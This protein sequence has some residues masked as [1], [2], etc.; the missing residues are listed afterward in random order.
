MSTLDQAKTIAE[1]ARREKSEKEA[2]AVQRATL[3][4]SSFQS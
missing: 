4:E 2:S 1:Q 3:L